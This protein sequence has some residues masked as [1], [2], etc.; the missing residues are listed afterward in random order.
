MRHSYGRCLAIE[1][2]YFNEGENQEPPVSLRHDLGSPQGKGCLAEGVSRG[3]PPRDKPDFVI[4]AHQHSIAA[5]GACSLEHRVV[6][7]GETVTDR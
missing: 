3:G 6:D 1:S 5:H 7:D 4:I 2:K